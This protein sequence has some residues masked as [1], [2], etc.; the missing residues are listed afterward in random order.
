VEIIF[1]VLE[2]G[3]AVKVHHGDVANTA[4]VELL[5]RH[6]GVVAARRTAVGGGDG[7]DSGSSADFHYNALLW[8]SR[9]AIGTSVG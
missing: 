9:W 8:G 7:Q 4:G 1:S 5:G 6:R 2:V 3:K